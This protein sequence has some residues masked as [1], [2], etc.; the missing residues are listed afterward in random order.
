[1]MGDNVASTWGTLYEPDI[2]TWRVRELSE[3]VEDRDNRGF[4]LGYRDY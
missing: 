3:E 2:S 1:M 4:F